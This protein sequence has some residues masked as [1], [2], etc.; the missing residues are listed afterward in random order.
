VSKVSGG[1]V[2]K[3]IAIPGDQDISRN[4]VQ[5]AVEGDTV[6][7]TDLHSRNGTSVVLP[8]KAPQ[9]LRQGEPTSVLVGTIVDLGGGVTI[10]VKEQS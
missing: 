7:V 8:G 1:S 6:V 5:F 2:P 10:T 9:L 4:H 3:L